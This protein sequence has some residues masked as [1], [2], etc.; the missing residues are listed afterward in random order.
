MDLEI[1]HLQLVQAIV[2]E[3]SLGA[4]AQRLHLSQPALS[5]QLRVLEERLGTL[6]FH[7]L[8]R[9][10]T[11]T[12]AGLQLVEAACRMLPE[13]TSLEGQLRQQGPKEGG[14]LRLA[15][16][17]FTG[18]RWMPEWMSK[19]RERWP[20]LE[21]RLV[22]EATRDPIRA[23]REG[24][25]DLAILDWRPDLAG[26]RVEP[27]FRDRMA[28][29]LPIDH[30]LAQRH[31]VDPKDL[32]VHRLLQPA[33]LDAHNPLLLALTN[34]GQSPV[35]EVIPLVEAIVALVRGGA[36]LSILP[37][38]LVAPHLESGLVAKPLGHPPIMRPWWI[39]LPEPMTQA[40][41]W[42]DVLRA[43]RQLGEEGRG[44]ERPV[45]RGKRSCPA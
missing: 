9:G 43:L 5:H 14:L 10:L 37:L 28:V 6:L 3:G 34:A 42:E 20:A 41:W 21:I 36:G 15:T 17:C 24:R 32:A 23:L 13:L 7:R 22:P 45:G 30:P 29:V 11:P 26:L 25:L 12:P 4:A 33:A 2:G 27:L 31:H 18:Y 16:G 35:V 1:R 8:G 39:A 40:P 19:V 44:A 38:W